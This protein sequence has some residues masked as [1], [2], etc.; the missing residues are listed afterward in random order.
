MSGILGALHSQAIHYGTLTAGN[1]NFGGGLQQRGLNPSV[2]SY[3]PAITS[4]LTFREILDQ[5][6]PGFQQSEVQVTGFTANPGRT[7][8]SFVIANGTTLSEPSATGFLYDAPNGRATWTF[9]TAFNFVSLS[10]YSVTLAY[11]G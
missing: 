9:A 1:Q 5:Y 2:G 3:T 11:R 10:V 6:N 4:S 8:L 7:W